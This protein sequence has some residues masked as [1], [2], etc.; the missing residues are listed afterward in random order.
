MCAMRYKDPSAVAFTPMHSSDVRVQQ[1]Q[2]RT[3]LWCIPSDLGE[4]A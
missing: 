2:H 1:Q 3:C 4:G